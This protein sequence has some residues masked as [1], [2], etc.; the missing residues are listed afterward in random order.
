M[1]PWNVAQLGY[2]FLINL[3]CTIYGTV[4]EFLKHKQSDTKKEQ[5]PTIHLESK[6]QKN[7]NKN[8]STFETCISAAAR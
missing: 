1:P 6:E 5:L 7:V 8:C 2:F 3:A 4:L